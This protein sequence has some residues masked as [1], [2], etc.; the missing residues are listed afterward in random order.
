MTPRLSG[1]FS[2]FGLVFF[3]LKSLPGI[4]RQWSPEKFAVLS[5][6]LSANGRNNSQH[7]W[8][9]NAGSCW[10]WCANRCN[11]SQQCWNL[12]ATTCNRL[13]KRMQH[14]TSMQ[15]CWEL[16]VNNVAFVC[17]GFKPRSRVRILIYRTWAITRES[18]H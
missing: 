12:H 11:N 1:H 2:I 6:K 9:K 16:L 14:I 13:C 10:Q 3:V 7:C 8:V 15:Q 4:A 18:F 5:L 17:T